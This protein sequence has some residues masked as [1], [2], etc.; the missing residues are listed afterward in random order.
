MNDQSITVLGPYYDSF[1]DEINVMIFVNNEPTNW[2]GLEAA[3]CKGIHFE[4][5]AMKG[6]SDQNKRQEKGLPSPKFVGSFVSLAEAAYTLDFNPRNIENP[7][8]LIESGYHPPVN[9]KKTKQ[10]YSDNLGRKYPKPLRHLNGQGPIVEGKHVR[11]S[12]EK[13]MTF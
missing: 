6:C 10:E 11:A 13:F 2:R 3:K 4:F 12:R 8:Y 1:G 5:R 9:D 7:K